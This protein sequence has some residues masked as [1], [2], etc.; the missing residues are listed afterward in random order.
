ML[1]VCKAS[2]LGLIRPPLSEI[3]LTCLQ[4]CFAWF[5]SDRNF[6]IWSGDYRWFALLLE[7]HNYSCKKYLFREI[8]TAL[9]QCCKMEKY[10]YGRTAVT[11]RR[12][13]TGHGAEE[14][15]HRGSKRQ[16]TDRELETTQ[17]WT[18]HPQSIKEILAW[19]WTILVLGVIRKKLHI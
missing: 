4:I 14:F 18:I 11:W 19:S 3:L 1:D 12:E 2:G 5:S 7:Q 8:Y 17:Q 13:D 6:L 10:I 15:R 16:G 9:I